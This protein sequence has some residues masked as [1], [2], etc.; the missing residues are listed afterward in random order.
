ML[1]KANALNAP[2]LGLI[3]PK[4]VLRRAV[5]R[6]RVKRMLREWFRCNQSRLGSRD[7]LIRVT[8]RVVLMAE[9]ERELAGPW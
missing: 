7:I 5:D 6:N 1:L 3:V 2:R 4:R 8:K 9:V